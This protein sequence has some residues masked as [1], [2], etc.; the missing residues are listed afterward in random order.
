MASAK[1]NYL[2]SLLY[3]VL[4]IIIPL[5]TT[6]Y[7]TRGLGAASLG[8]YAVHFS[9]ASYF[10]MFI[11]MGLD[12]YGN[13]TIASI[14]ENK[15][16][17]YNAFWSI[18]MMQLCFSVIATVLYVVYCIFI[19][20]DIRLSIIMGIYIFS[21]IIDITWLFYGLE[22]FKITVTRSVI[23]K[24]VSTICIF[25]F[26]H[27]ESDLVAYSIIMTLSFFI[28]QALLWPFVIRK[29]KV[30]HV[31]KQDIVIHVKPN[32]ILFIP[33]LAVSLYT[34]MDKIMLG[35]L[36]NSTQV[37]YYDSS[38]K[39]IQ[40]PLAFITSLGAVMLPKVSNMYANKKD[41]DA[42][43]L[44]GKSIDLSMFLSS[45]LSFGIMGIANTFVPW[46]YGN[47]F[48]LCIDLFA[49]L[50][51]SCLFVSFANV[52]RTQY[53]IPKKKDKVYIYSVVL[54]AV[55][56]MILNLFLIP[57]LQSIG[58]S[59]ATF[60]AEG[61]VFGLQVFLI[62]KE[63]PVMK[64]IL[65]SIKYVVFGVLMYYVL[66]N[67]NFAAFSELYII[68]FKTVIGATIYMLLYFLYRIIFKKGLPDIKSIFR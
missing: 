57:G 25:I 17:L 15:S 28:N 63:L 47:D 10:V 49:I 39:I 22:E 68:V 44:F 64:Y 54:G 43:R 67:I 56:N 13:R 2:Y 7:L 48:S 19:S 31:T 45:V 29:I 5:I 20:S 65:Q 61:C 21:A 41:E 26:V 12:N 42:I 38:E 60:V 27:N 16:N 23:V 58:A 46:Y 9:I 37:G 24:L 50:L 33:V 62:R 35:Y 8:E 32:L 40:I 18:Y 51:P 30:C 36:S 11:K 6:P 59:I 4:T 66:I 53:L 1:I 52:V 14:R 3:K 55:V 34:I